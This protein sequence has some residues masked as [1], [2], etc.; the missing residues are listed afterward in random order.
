MNFLLFWFYLLWI[1]KWWKNNF[2]M[3]AEKI[4]SVNH[5]INVLEHYLSQKILVK[6]FW[7]LG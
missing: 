4:Q 6:S 5:L 2:Y 1:K 3:D 7:M